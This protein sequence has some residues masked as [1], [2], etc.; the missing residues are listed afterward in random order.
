MASALLAIG[1][2]LFVEGL[3]YALAPAAV[4]EMLRMLRDLTTDQRR[5]FGLGAVAVGVALVWLAKALGA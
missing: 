5:A 2:V 1:L 4:E 3:I